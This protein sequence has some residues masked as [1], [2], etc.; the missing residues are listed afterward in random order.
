MKSTAPRARFFFGRIMKTFDE[1]LRAEGFPLSTLQ[2]TAGAIFKWC[3]TSASFQ[4]TPRVVEAQYGDGYAQRRAD[5]INTQ[6]REWTV[7]M[8]ETDPKTASDVL[9]FLQARNGV[10]VFNWTPPRSS[11]TLNV[12]CPTWS[13]SYGTQV[14]DG[15]RQMNITMTFREVFQ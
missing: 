5:G 1:W 11:Q 15:S 4:V 12:I 13:S 6:A 9:T 7:E 14:M 3:A 10:D 2:A 8:Q